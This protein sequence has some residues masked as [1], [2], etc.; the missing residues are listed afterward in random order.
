MIMKAVV[1]NCNGKG[2][3]QKQ[4]KYVNDYYED[5]PLFLQL[6]EIGTILNDKNIS[7]IVT[8]LKKDWSNTFKI[9][10]FF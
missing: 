7:S 6:K 8:R 3:T 4:I 2:S 1:S 5:E 9:Y 10:Q